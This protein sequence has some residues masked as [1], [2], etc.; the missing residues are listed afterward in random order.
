MSA[1]IVQ[2]IQEEM[3]LHIKYCEGFGLTKTQL[4][5]HKEH[6]GKVV[7]KYTCNMTLT[8]LA[9][10]TAYTRYVLDIGQSEDWFGLQI[11]LMPCLIG[12]GHIAR[13]LYDDP[14]TKREE[15]S[16]WNWVEQ[17][18]AE[19]YTE[20]VKAGL[21]I[22]EKHA[23]LQSPS[24]IEQLVEIFIHATKVNHPLLASHLECFCCPKAC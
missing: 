9:A 23:V 13:R 15:N 11:A 10:C 8:V 24:R 7:S 2:H 20:A 19:D 17:Y 21:E 16:Y 3:S 12:Y 14:E 5:S 6:P 18:V 22:I 1:R 4:E